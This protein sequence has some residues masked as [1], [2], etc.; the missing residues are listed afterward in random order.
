MFHFLY[1]VTQRSQNCEP[2]LLE[3]VHKTFEM[4][5]RGGDRGSA[6]ARGRGGARPK[7]R[8]RQGQQQQQHNFKNKPHAPLDAPHRSSA[9]CIPR[10]YTVSIAVPGSVVD[11][12]QSRELKTILVGQIARAAAIHHIDEVRNSEAWWYSR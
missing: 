9:A 10:Y 7:K 4:E 2:P 3:C 5:Q 8:A 1:C 12:A 6:D 11:N